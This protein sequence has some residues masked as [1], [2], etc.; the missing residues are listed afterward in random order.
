[1][2]MFD[3]LPSE[4]DII[5]VGTGIVESI[6]ASACAR[7]GKTVLHVDTNEY[8]GS[9]WASF[10]LNGLIEWAQMQENPATNVDPQDDNEKIMP[11]SSPLNVFR[12]V[13]FKWNIE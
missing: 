8:Y 6:L 13:Q 11:I 1:E 5:V 10:P 7:I 12:N 4:Y 2:K 9:E 3:G